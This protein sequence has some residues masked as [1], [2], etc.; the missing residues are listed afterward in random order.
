VLFTNSKKLSVSLKPHVYTEDGKGQD[1][2]LINEGKV[3]NK[4]KKRPDDEQIN[5]MMMRPNT[6][7]RV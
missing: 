1:V 7:V 6:A 2:T 3:V 5:N 4:N